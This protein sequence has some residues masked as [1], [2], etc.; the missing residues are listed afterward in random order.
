M[1]FDQWLKLFPRFALVSNKT[2]IYMKTTREKQPFIPVTCRITD[3]SRLIPKTFSSA[4]TVSTGKK[5]HDSDWLD[6]KEP[7]FYAGVWPPLLSFSYWASDV[8]LWQQKEPRAWLPS[9]SVT[10]T[11]I[12]KQA[13]AVKSRL[14]APS[15]GMKQ[16]WLYGNKTSLKTFIFKCVSLLST[17]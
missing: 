3:S 15:A 10:G 17:T 6:I 13:N 2:Q 12:S 5:K 9:M 1:S 8:L 16:K 7:D 4:I 14:D 11:S